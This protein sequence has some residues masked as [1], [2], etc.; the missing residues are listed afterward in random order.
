MRE[1]KKD[2]ISQ[3]KHVSRI[4]GIGFIIQISHVLQA[5][6]LVFRHSVLFGVVWFL[7]KGKL[8]EVGG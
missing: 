5:L 8:G 1:N 7:L 4:I 2:T 6:L 3:T